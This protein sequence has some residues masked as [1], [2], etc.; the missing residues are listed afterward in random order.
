MTYDYDQL[1]Y[2]DIHKKNLKIFLK[3]SSDTYIPK[4]KHYTTFRYARR[5]FQYFYIDFDLFKRLISLY[6]I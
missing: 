3:K 6:Y 2:L 5:F 4:K 1:E